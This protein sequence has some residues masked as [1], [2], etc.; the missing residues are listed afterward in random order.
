VA[1][2]DL[3]VTGEDYPGSPVWRTDRPKIVW[4]TAIAPVEK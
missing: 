2:E 3:A 1:D 4:I